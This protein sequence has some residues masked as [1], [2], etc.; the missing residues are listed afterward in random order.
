MRVLH[1]L[2]QRPGL[3]GSGVFFNSII[4]EGAQR[5]LEQHA[6]VAGPSTTSAEEVPDVA[7]DEFTLIPFPSSQAPFL[8]PGNSDV[9]PYP[10]TIFSRMTPSQIEAYLETSRDVM[11][12]LRRS[13]RPDVVHTHHLWLMTSLARDVFR[14]VPVIAT[15]HNSELRQLI[16]GPHLAPQVL[17]GIQA[18]DRVCVLTPRSL[19]DTAETF[20][21]ARSR[22]EVTGAGFREDLFFF[23]DEPTGQILSRLKSD[24]GIEL[25]PSHTRQRPQLI[26]FAGRLSSSKGVPYLVEAFRNLLDR[27]ERNLQLILIGA[28]GS[29]SDGPA[30]GRLVQEAGSSVV[31]LG[32]IPQQA[33][34]LIFQAADLFVLPSLFEG[35]PLVML[36]AAACGCPCLVTDLQPIESWVPKSWIEEGMFQFIPRLK[37]TDADRPDGS[38]TERFVRD[39][40][41]GIEYQ[42]SSV[43]PSGSGRQMAEK[44]KDHSWSAVFERYL[45]IYRQLQLSVY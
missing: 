1:V 15:A 36:E 44:L 7:R 9:M 12:H 13:F 22:I 34:G 2:S 17:P 27:T 23:S 25:F 18:L 33:V 19:A 29:G 8:V 5:G 26:V 30:V 32:A 45:K 21:V 3:S 16:K 6:I 4:R 41:A 38:D 24:F 42:L 11:S 28:V 14:D 31:S 20:Q 10:S 39:I 37:T 35:L 43:R 40:E